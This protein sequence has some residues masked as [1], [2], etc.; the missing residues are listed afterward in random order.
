[1]GWWPN[2]SPRA[3]AEDTRRPHPPQTH[4]SVPTDHARTPAT[5]ERN[6][7][8]ARATER[9]ALHRHH[10]SGARELIARI[11]ADG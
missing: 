9:I 10:A 2:D 3:F 4:S 6:A 1:M 5:P 11:D 7:T 8:G